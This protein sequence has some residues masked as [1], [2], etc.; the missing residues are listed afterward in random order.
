MKLDIKLPEDVLKLNEVFQD[1]GYELYLVGGC[2]RDSLLNITPKDY[3]LVTNALPDQIISILKDNTLITKIL[4]TGKA[5][6]VINVLTENDE[7]EIAT[8]REDGDS[9]DNRHPDSIKFSTIEIDAQRRDLTINALYLNIN[10]KEIIDLVGGVEDLLNRKIR[11]V[12]NPEDR[13]KEDKLRILRAIRMTYRFD[14]R[15]DNE[16]RYLLESGLDLE[17]ISHE[18]IKDEFF[19]GIKTSKSPRN[20]VLSLY[21]YKLIKYVFGSNLL[22]A[23]NCNNESNPIVLIANLLKD[24]EIEGIK[25]ELNRLCYSTDEIKRIVFLIT[26]ISF[27]PE[28]TYKLKKLQLSSGVSNEEVM[29]FAN[30]NDYI[31]DPHLINLFLSFN[32]SVTGAEL[33]EKG[34][35][36]GIALGRLIEEMENK[37]FYLLTKIF[38]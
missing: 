27:N 1:N 4:E 28:D 20:Y 23:D 16:L 22:I 35:K 5:F 13:F 33:I 34:M 9:T 11:T 32:L 14:F 24:N 8:F 21:G 30:W 18:R 15:L 12:G 38:L 37:N 31:L 17:G 10:T 3:D 19:K 2:V 26:L 25:K 29:A 36:P 7:Y 6:G